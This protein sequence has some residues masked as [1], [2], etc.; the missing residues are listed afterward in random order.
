MTVSED[1]SVCRA[2]VLMSRRTVLVKLFAAL[3]VE[4]NPDAREV[5]CQTISRILK[6]R[7]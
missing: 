2:A 3:M 7:C 6:E 4:E 5:I 1:V